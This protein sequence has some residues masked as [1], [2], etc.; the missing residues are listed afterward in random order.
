VLYSSDALRGYGILATDGELGSVEDFFFDDGSWTVRYIVVD[1]GKWLPGKHVLITPSVIG[2]PDE[3]AG[4]I[5]VSLTREQVKNSPDV[6]T[7][8]PVSRLKEIEM[9]QYYGWPAYWDSGVIAAG[10]V[11][12]PPPTPQAVR[13]IRELTEDLVDES[14][15]NLR[16]TH[17]LMGYGIQAADNEIGSVSELLFEEDT[18]VVRYLVI[19]TGVIF[20]GKRVLISPEWVE[21]ISWNDRK[22]FVT[23]NTEMIRSA[24][25]FDKSLPLSREF[26]EALHAHYGRSRYWQPR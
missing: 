15:P 16:S 13:D 19:S 1:T 8:K 20:A 25:E 2:R 12:A 3:K 11:V 5:S 18:W 4:L 17:D 26:E 7:R 9:A 10:P 14:K 24:P 6:D 22:V 21:R 23:L